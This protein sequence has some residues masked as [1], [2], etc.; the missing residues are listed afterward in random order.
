MDFGLF[1]PAYLYQTKNTHTHTQQIFKPFRL[2]KAIFQLSYHIYSLNNNRHHT[3]F[4]IRIYFDER[5]WWHFGIFVKYYV[6]FDWQQFYFVRLN[7]VQSVYAAHKPEN[8]HRHHTKKRNWNGIGAFCVLSDHCIFEKVVRM[9]DFRYVFCFLRRQWFW[10]TT[11]LPMVLR[12][13]V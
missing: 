6:A 1:S 3:S 4:Y 12:L 7:S 2:V 9:I 5:K 11:F 8:G 13:L 10:C